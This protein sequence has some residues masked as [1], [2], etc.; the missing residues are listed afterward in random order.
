MTTR[1]GASDGHLTIRGR[2]GYLTAMA[3]DAGADAVIYLVLGWLAARTGDGVTA[4]SVLAAATIPTVIVLLAG[5]VVGDRYGLV[6]VASI[7]LSVR[8]VL[9]VIFA[10]TVA[11]TV[12]PGL[13]FL[14]TL[15]ALIGLAD[16]V[17]MPAMGGLAGLLAPEGQQASLQG[18]VLSSTRLAGLL[19]TA[20]GG[21]L[22]GFSPAWALWA[23]A[24]LLVVALVPIM[25]LRR[26]ESRVEEENAPSFMAMLTAGLHTIAGDRPLLALLLTLALGNL[27]GSA[28]V[29]LGVPLKGVAGGWSGAVYGVVY[30]CFGLGSA[31]GAA[32]VASIQKRAAQHRVTVALLLLLGGAVG[33]AG[34]ALA[35]SAL[36]TGVTATVTGA[37][38]A[39]AAAFLMGEIRE[40]TAPEMMGRVSSAAQLAIFG[41]IPVGYFVFG[42]LVTGIGLTSAGLAMAGGLAVVVC[43]AAAVVASTTSR[44]QEL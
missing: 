32:A 38:F 1:S 19:A 33:L 39:P 35:S 42:L 10:V 37:F 5:G 29:L 30:L 18:W 25:S 44:V 12:Q 43:V 28:P 15:A 20:L 27:A 6:R 2:L 14:V 11:S 41:L 22:L 34:L 13:T 23:A 8:V 24:A 31:A 17:H 9:L 40:R 4:A 16:A 21:F 36:W 3:A 26:T 7:T